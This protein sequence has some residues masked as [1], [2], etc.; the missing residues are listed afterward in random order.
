M[1]FLLIGLDIDLSLLWENLWSIVVAVVAVLVSR[2]AVVYGLSWIV[3]LGRGRHRLPLRWR[4]VLFWGG[5]RGA[6]SLALALSLPVSLPERETLEAMTF[7]V[8]LFS[9]LGQGTTIQFLLKRLGLIERPE[10]VVQRERFLARLL[11]AQGGLHRLE[12]LRSDGILVDEMWKGMRD[13]YTHIRAALEDEIN[14]L[15]AEHAELE[16]ELLLQ[17][18]KE[19]LEAEQGALIDALR[20]GVI[21][22]EVFEELRA[23]IDRRLEALAVI[24]ASIRSRGGA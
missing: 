18:R 22:E 17:T 13:D 11:A 20:R 6:I 5:L 24:Q 10:S 7:G 19:T 16:R 4:H 9:L 21:S 12:E 3:F 15:F 1:V 8:M 14:L 23:D 2:A